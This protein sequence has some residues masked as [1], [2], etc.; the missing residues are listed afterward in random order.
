MKN[1][2]AFSV[3]ILIIFCVIVTVQASK[4]YNK[5]IDEGHRNAERMVNSLSDH[6]E[7]TFNSIDLNMRRAI[8][9]QYLNS[10]FGG[11]IPQDV[12]NNIKLW[13]QNSPQIIGMYM[14]DETGKLN[15]SVAKPQHKG[16]LVNSR[17]Y[18][19]EIFF[20][21]TKSAPEDETHVWSSKEMGLE[22]PNIFLG[23]KIIDVDGSFGGIIVSVVDPAYIIDYFKSIETGENSFMALSM[24]DGRIIASGPQAS[25]EI[26]TQNIKTS[27]SILSFIDE[28]KKLKPSS[29]E[30]ITDLAA[31]NDSIK[32][33]SHRV[34]KQMPLKVTVLLDE[35]DFL[36]DWGND[37]VKDIGFLAIFAI[38]GSVLSFFAITMARQI[39][40]VEE[41]EASAVLASQ[42][43]S[44]FLANM[45][46][47]LRTPLNAIIGFSE[48]LDS[49]YFGMLNQKQR[50]RIHDINL[51]GNHLLQLI[52]DIL[53]FSKGEAGKLELQDE[54]MDIADV[55]AECIRIMSERAKSKMVYLT[56]ENVA[57]LPHLFGD[58]RKIRQIL[59]NL[60]SNAIKFT[61]ADGLVSVSCSLD[62]YKNLMIVVKDTGIGIP[63]DEI[64]KALSVFGQVHR[65]MSHEGT[66]LGLPLCKMFTELH[67][68]KLTLESKV[69]VGTTVSIM[70]P[71]QRLMFADLSKNAGA[72][73]QQPQTSASTT[74]SRIAATL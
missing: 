41:S 49:G 70:M 31:S 10:L 16:L 28:N 60:L 48:M 25:D 37:R 61:S 30:A 15:F 63:E 13:V 68:G 50:E 56:A 2:I 46:H 17:N 55:V 52:N 53:E 21:T 58:R 57:G 71:Y 54:E 7:L 72:N 3:L 14:I 67:G 38:F 4:A 47:E 23:R 32:I 22:N 5:A 20:I 29:T 33:F 65:N 45:S 9:R 26:S 44:E 19:S 6:I 59:L 69:G 35:Q 74:P 66:G 34:F 36:E 39:R 51:C 64:P 43:K 11:S 24:N 42:A 18:K 8:E 40:R 73:T 12:E 27:E 62:G 1:L